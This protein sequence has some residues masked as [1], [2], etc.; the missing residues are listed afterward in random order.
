MA[1]NQSEN[2]KVVV[3]IRPIQKHEGSRGEKIIVKPTGNGSEVQIKTGSKEAS[4]YKVNQ[5]F[6]RDTQQEE[7]FLNSGMTELLDSAIAGYR[8]CAFAF[9]QTGAG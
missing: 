2:I 8:A 9:G 7:F 6:P 4:T 1:S 3:R 5:C